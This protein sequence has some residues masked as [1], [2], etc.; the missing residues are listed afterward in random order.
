M[1]TVTEHLDQ[2]FE[3]RHGTVA[4]DSSL[5]EESDPGNKAQDLHQMGAKIGE[6]ADAHGGGPVERVKAALRHADRELGGEYERREDPEAAPSPQ[7]VKAEQ[8]PP[9]EQRETARREAG[10]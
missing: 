6:E 7:A 9:G 1:G 8:L 5:A 4:S 2:E 10:E 3:G